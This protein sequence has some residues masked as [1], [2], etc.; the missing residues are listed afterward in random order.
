MVRILDKAG[1]CFRPEEIG[2]SREEV[3]K[4]LN[5]LRNYVKEEKLPY[6]I[7]NEVKDTRLMEEAVEFIDSI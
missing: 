7:I 2:S 4:S 1:V 6:S 5:L 3:L